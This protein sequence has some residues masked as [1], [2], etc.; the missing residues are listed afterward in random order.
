MTRAGEH[1]EDDRHRLGDRSRYVLGWT[2]AAKIAA[3]EVK[4]RTLEAR[5]DEHRDKRSKIEQRQ[6]D[7]DTLRGQTQALLLEPGI[8][9]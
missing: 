2:N 6:S 1:H 3:L 9:A 4:A 8:T 5:L 7:A